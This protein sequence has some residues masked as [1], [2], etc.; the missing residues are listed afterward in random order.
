MQ[1][2]QDV[3]VDKADAEI[4]KEEGAVATLSTVYPQGVFI[5][6]RDLQVEL[7]KTKFTKYMKV[8]EI[9]AERGSW[10]LTRLFEDAK[11]VL[12]E[13]AFGVWLCKDFQW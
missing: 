10:I 5:S 12:Q 1:K 8:L 6:E 9:L 4:L 13:K 3:M 7:I 2:Y 11:G